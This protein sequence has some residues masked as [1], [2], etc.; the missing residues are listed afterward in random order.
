M[1]KILT[2]TGWILASFGVSILASK[3]TDKILD[4][5]Y[6]KITG[7][8]SPDRSVLHNKNLG[9]AVA[10]TLLIGAVSS[11]AKFAMTRALA[12]GWERAGGEL[13]EDAEE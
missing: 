13:P 4:K 8:E 11:L 2:K 3:V 12:Q 6:E 5:G 7:S 10:W 1:S 9:K